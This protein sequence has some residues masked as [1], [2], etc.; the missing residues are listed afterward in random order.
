MTDDYQLLHSGPVAECFISGDGTRVCKRYHEYLSADEFLHQQIIAELKLCAELQH[1][2]ILPIQEIECDS[3]AIRIYM[4]WVSPVS[5][6]DLNES[7]LIAMLR[8]CA[9]AL[10]YAHCMGHVHRSLH[11]GNVHRKPDGTFCISD[12]F[13][14]RNRDTCTLTGTSFIPMNTDNI[15]PELLRACR[16]DPR[17]DIFS[18]GKTALHIWN[19]AAD[20]L[21]NT[22][23]RDLLTA[24][25][26][27]AA[28]RPTSAAQLMQHLYERSAPGRGIG[29]CPFCGVPKV[30]RLRLCPH[31]NKI[32]PIPT[33]YDKADASALILTV[34]T[35][36][37]EQIDIIRSILSHFSGRPMS[38]LELISGDIRKYSKAER[39]EYLPQ[40]IVLAAPISES[41]A[42]EIIEVFYSRIHH[43]SI[44]LLKH[45]YHAVKNDRNV[46]NQTSLFPLAAYA[47][48][49]HERQFL[50]NSKPYMP[51]QASDMD[52]QQQ[53]LAEAARILRAF[54]KPAD[55]HM[56]VLL[57]NMFKAVDSI[58]QQRTWL[59]QPR[60]LDLYYQSG[61]EDGQTGGLQF[62]LEEL[63]KKEQD[64]IRLEQAILNQ[65]HRLSV[66]ARKASSCP[67]LQ[68]LVSELGIQ[69][70][71]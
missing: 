68:A 4:P 65:L 19:K 44:S 67:D 70:F 49:D 30:R 12:F 34:T 48:S 71:L 1:E 63:R 43:A 15:A 53:A 5:P 35:E 41:N 40:G 7:E 39:H 56:E 36:D 55:K 38:E 60:L 3:E 37:S 64:C 2:N 11:A 54:G 50:Q 27:Q 21:D 42:D 16:T 69:A 17:I 66:A 51:A 61:R 47:H 29:P 57:Q 59:Q 32:E 6:G 20:D 18:L 22:W 14:G 23:L 25:Q 58:R 24:M 46:R 10:H 26:G 45:R 62:E 9:A 33:Y 52:H 31:C 8:D 28:E 13:S